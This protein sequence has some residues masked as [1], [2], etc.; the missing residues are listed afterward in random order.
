MAKV[1]LWKTFDMPVLL[2]LNVGR[3]WSLLKSDGSF[4][5]HDDHD[6]FSNSDASRTWDAFHV[7]D[8]EA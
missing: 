6:R 8:V 4:S 3:A 5:F 2:W 7:F 1:F